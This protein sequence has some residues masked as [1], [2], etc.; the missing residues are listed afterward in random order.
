[1]SL[2]DLIGSSIIAGAIIV[3][4]IAL[5]FVL[6]GSTIE[7]KND[8]NTQETMSE[9]TKVLQWDIAKIGYGVPDE[10]KVLVASPDTLCFR[11]DIDN[12][13][14]LDTVLYRKGTPD[15]LPETQ[16]PNDFVLYRTVSGGGTSKTAAIKVGLVSFTMAYLDST[17]GSTL[18]AA[19]VRGL[20][21][22]ALIQSEYTLPDADYA[23]VYWENTMYPRN[24]N[25]R[26]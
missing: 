14:A 15:L 21:F 3:A 11:G 6:S 17:G 19:N 7:I 24:L 2:I 8:L 10:A 13:G 16:N 25:L 23:G 20:K 18:V 9:F 22:E 26:K 5:T 12:D 4:I 1:M